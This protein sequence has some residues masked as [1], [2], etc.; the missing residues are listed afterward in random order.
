MTQVDRQIMILSQVYQF[1][2]PKAKQTKTTMQ[3]DVA[4]VR[5]DKWLWAARF[6][7]TRSLAS[8]AISGGKVQCQNQ[9]VKN[10]RSVALGDEY[11][12]RQ[13]YHTIT[14]IVKALSGKR[15]SA[16]QAALLYEET[17]DSIARREQ[18]KLLRQAQPALRDP[19]MGRPSK[20]ER[21]HIIAFTKKI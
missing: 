13:G 15:G 7:K 19:G 4:S 16:S 6:Y 1:T 2:M 11:T 17:A 20:R 12:I 14:I 9:R 5:I 3:Q 21:R 10:S 8:E 18:D